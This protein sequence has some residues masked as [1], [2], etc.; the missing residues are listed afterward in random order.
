VR[1]ATGAPRVTVVMASYNHADFVEAAV[2]SVLGQST[3][4]LELIVVDDGSSDRTPD[5]VA[6]VDDDRLTLVRLPDNRAVHPR[7]VALE[8][9]RGEL[10]AFQNSDDVWAPTKLETQLAAFDDTAVSACFTGVRIVDAAGRPT[11]ADWLTGVFDTEPRTQAQWLRHFFDSGNALCISSAVCRRSDLLA[12]GGFDE[13]LVQLSDLDLWVR[14]AALGRLE[15]LPEP[16]TDM[17]VVA[18]RNASAPSDAVVHRGTLEW[19]RVLGRYARRPVQQW[20]DEAFPDVV[21]G[22]RSRP[23][24]L[25]RLARHGWGH[26]GAAQRLFGDRLFEHLLSRPGARERIVADLGS[27]VIHEFLDQRGRIHVDVDG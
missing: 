20:L 12:V 3:G 6:A 2:A 11:T 1:H 21:E 23:V 5:L 26:G 17:R 16:L 18:G 9:A 22:R 24:R 13:S 25:A 15:V 27:G 14:L 19:A 8:M 10:V 7:A 4:D